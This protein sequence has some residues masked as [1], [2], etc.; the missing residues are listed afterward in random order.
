[1]S[2]SHKKVAANRI[3]GE[4]SQGPINTTSTRFNATK[5]GLLAVGI[6][7]LDNAEGYRN[8][9]S[10]LMREKN[11]VGVIE[12]FLVESAAIE[13]VRWLRAR[14]L[15]AECITGEL[16]PPT[17]APGLC[18]LLLLEGGEVLDPGLPAAISAEAAQKL[19]TFQRYESTSANRFFR[20]LHELERWQR[21]RSGERV[22]APAVVDISVHGETGTADSILDDIKVVESVSAASGTVDSGPATL[23]QAKALLG[24]EVGDEE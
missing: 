11:P 7:E 16:N 24:D 4:K 21:M 14:R 5:H 23:E 6:T 19:V 10:D 18:N 17:H 20:I 15:E 13:M 9:L 1:M 2:S 3:N 12:T 22:P 8:I